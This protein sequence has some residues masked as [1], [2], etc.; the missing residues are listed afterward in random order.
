MPTRCAQ[1]PR[2]RAGLFGLDGAANAE[3]AP[4]AGPRYLKQALFATAGVTGVQTA[5]ENVD[6]LRSGVEEF[7]GILDIA[8]A[9]TL[10]LAVLIAF[11]AASGT[12]DE[13][14]RENATMFAFG[15]PLRT[16]L[17]MTVV[18]SALL[19]ALGTAVGVLL[20]QGI[21]A[22]QSRYNSPGPYRR[23]ASMSL[24]PH[25]PT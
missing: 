21:G 13:R 8:A 12:A 2:S 16:V 15:L 10:A 4:G 24:W 20:G 19:G 25:V 3:P 14:S 9:V 6:A 18:E 22:G 11:N 23:S 1:W 5:I 7:T 17:T